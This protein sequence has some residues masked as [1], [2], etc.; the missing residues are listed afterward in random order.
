MTFPTTIQQ[1][2]RA[3]RQDG[4][5]LIELMISMALG[6]LLLAAITSLIVSQ[7]GH[8]DELEKSS[9]QI[10]NG[11]YASQ[12]LR[13]D[14]QHAGFYGQAFV[15]N[16]APYLVPSASLAIPDP[17]ITTPVTG[18]GSLLEAMSLPIQGYDSASTT[19]VGC[20]PAADFV[21]GTDVLVI[22]RADT[23]YVASKPGDT[24][25]QDG[26]VYLQ[27][28]AA[29][30]VMA[31]GQGST[32]GT[33]TSTF[34][35]FFDQLKQVAAPVRQ[36]LVHIYFISPCSNPTGPASPTYNIATCRATDDNGH[37]IPTLMRLELKAAPTAPSTTA[38]TLVPL[39]EGIES[40]QF[41][42]GLDTTPA[43]T[44]DGYPDTYTTAPAASL[45]WS[46]VMAVRIN[47]LA[48]NLQCT[49]GYKD[50]KT[51][52]LGLTTNI[53]PTAASSVGCTNGDYKRHV[54][55]ELVRVINPSSRLAAQ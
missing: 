46:E 20:I 41:D 10:E 19:P 28:S 48:R 12:I 16:A 4:L 40:M 14:I 25:P 11:R 30:T 39:V 2:A 9:E 53:A 31:V 13:D 49:T 8:R 55:T 36:Y 27:A 47:L 33:S 51:Y 24:I 18:T 54:F 34:S 26:N 45:G 23:G 52:S 6:L 7:S 1:R 17:C 43:P 21:P 38:W 44:G 37:P 35:L 3:R 29:S 32:W 5:S 50:T 22:R 42:Y 15:F